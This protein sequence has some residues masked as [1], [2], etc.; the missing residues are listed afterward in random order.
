MCDI[1]IAS[2]EAKFAESFV[3]LGII[4]GDGGAWLLPR[5]IGLSRAAELTFTGQTID[6]QQALEWNLVSRVV[7]QRDLLATAR[8]MAE[9]IAANRRTPCAWPSACCAKACI[10]GWTRCWKCRRRS[11]C[12]R[13][14]RPIIT[15]RWRRFI[16][17]VRQRSMDRTRWLRVPLYRREPSRLSPWDCSHA[18]EETS[19]YLTQA[20]NVRCS[21]RQ[22]GGD[23]FRGRRRTFREF[24]ERVARLAGALRGSA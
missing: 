8:D 16:E 23:I 3:K 11:R 22:S 7:P 13:T 10:P 21:R 2:E 4:P 6:A 24:G 19:M 18:A 5:I 20:F 12:C 15:K 14:R 9:E 17:S 1:R